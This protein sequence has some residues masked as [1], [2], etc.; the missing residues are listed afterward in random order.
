[1]SNEKVSD[2]EFFGGLVTSFKPVGLTNTDMVALRNAIVVTNSNRILKRKS[3]MDIPLTCGTAR[4]YHM[5]SE[6]SNSPVVRVDL[7]LE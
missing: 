1:M 3:S 7:K 5:A 2:E 4:V 6:N